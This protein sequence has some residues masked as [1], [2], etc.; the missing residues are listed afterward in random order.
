MEVQSYRSTRGGGKDASEDFTPT[1]QVNQNDRRVQVESDATASIDDD[2]DTNKV[3]DGQDQTE[4][5]R[6]ISQTHMV[7][8]VHYHKTGRALAGKLMEAFLRCI[9]SRGKRNPCK[10]RVAGRT[11]SPAT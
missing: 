5:Q 7:V 4:E 2:D 8:A 3:S 6:Q 9:G 1:K 11:H 10:R